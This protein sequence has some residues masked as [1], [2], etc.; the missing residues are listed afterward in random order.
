MNDKN[1]F[2]D[3][4]PTSGEQWKLLVE[5]ELKGKP[6]DSLVWNTGEGF[7]ISPF[8]TLSGSVPAKLPSKDLKTCAGW[9]I[10]Q[11]IRVIESNEANREALDGLKYGSDSLNFILEKISEK[12]F[13]ILLRKLN[14][15]QVELNFSSGDPVKILQWIRH[16]FSA[17]GKISEKLEG[18]VIFSPF[19]NK[20]LQKEVFDV[21]DHLM[22]FPITFRG[23]TISSF[24]EKFITKQISSALAGSHQ[25][26]SQ[27]CKSGYKAEEI[28]SRFQFSFPVSDNYFF[29]IAKIRAFRILWS[30]MLTGMGTVGQKTHVTYIHS[31]VIPDE[32][33]ER[34]DRFISNSSRVFSAAIGGADSVSVESD[35]VFSRNVNRNIQLVAKEESNIFQV[36]DVSAGSYYLEAL[37]G[38]IA[39][40][41]QKEIP[42]CFS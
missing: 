27:L 1:L 42:G 23:I 13:K 20:I 33:S 6:F 35:D 32:L 9:K 18:S 25:I 17:P 19:K 29:E 24:G 30:L 8:Y 22:E 7:D 14:P 39:M 38:K 41:V 31:H 28:A 3:F 15:G 10:R 34:D 26:I 4:A 16:N 40:Q 36:S 5:K 12:D 21:V 11:D 2:A 37:T